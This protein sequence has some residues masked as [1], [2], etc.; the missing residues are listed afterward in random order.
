MTITCDISPLEFKAIKEG[1]QNFYILK[2]DKV[3]DIGDTIIFHEKN[4]D[5][6]YSGQEQQFEITYIIGDHVGMKKDFRTLGWYKQK[7]L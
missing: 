4:E 1:K 2:S 5:G 3:N 7:E 6:S